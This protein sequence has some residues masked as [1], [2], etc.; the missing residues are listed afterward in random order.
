MSAT[1]ASFMETM[2]T[3][4]RP[5]SRPGRTESVVADIKPWR[6]S[7]RPQ[8]ESLG[9]DVGT[10]GDVEFES[11]SPQT[12]PTN[13]PQPDQGQWARGT[14]LRAG[15]ETVL[16]EIAAGD[17]VW[18]VPLPRAY[19]T[20]EVGYGTSI[21]IGI[22][23]IDGFRTPIVEVVGIEPKHDPEIAALRDALQAL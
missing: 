22:Q 8:T 15:E 13:P 2:P 1:G 18:E 16:C 14:V 17:R 11:L 23:S 9:A 7:R 5:T 21:R 6:A 19:F 3:H 4:P 10:A 20:A 12:V